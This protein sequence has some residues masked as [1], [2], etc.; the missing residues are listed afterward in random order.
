[1]SLTKGAQTPVMPYVGT[2]LRDVLFACDGN[3]DFIEIS[4]GVKVMNFDRM[5]MVG[6]QVRLFVRTRRIR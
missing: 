4:S 2:Y 5:H 3:P 1:M 6:L